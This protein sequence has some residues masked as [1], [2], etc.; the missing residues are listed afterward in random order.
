MLGPF[1]SIDVGNSHTK[2][3][4]HRAG[5]GA[6]ERLLD[7]PNDARV[8]EALEGALR[9]ALRGALQGAQGGREPPP[10]GVL[11][12]G[13]LVSVA[14]P[15][16]EAALREVVEGVLGR[17]VPV[18][19]SSGL[20]LAVLRPETVG[21]DRLFAARGALEVAGGSA[22]V[23]DAGTA[24]TVDAVR[25]RSGECPGTF[26]GGAIAPGPTLLARALTL[27]GA[28][29]PPVEPEPGAPALGRDTPGALAAGVAVGFE[30]AALRLVERVA[31][32]AGLEGAGVVL[33]GGAR[34]Y[35]EEALGSRGPDLWVEPFLVN[36]GLAAALA[37]G[38]GR[39]P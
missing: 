37:P 12:E 36:L 11:V 10:G 16:L 1:L 2:A 3:C 15:V 14:D 17:A 27:G 28:R 7:H 13:A 35:L 39:G 38:S 23:V 8:V 33:S 32:E 29:L 26:L 34:A 21:A 22:L 18:N 9:G 4:L 19:P 5:G 20:S 31:A 6:P 24:L 25:R 30:G